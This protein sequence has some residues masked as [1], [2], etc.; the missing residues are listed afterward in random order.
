MI[1]EM[2]GKVQRLKAIVC[3][4]ICKLRLQIKDLVLVSVL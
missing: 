4:E 3:G 2:F 1:Q